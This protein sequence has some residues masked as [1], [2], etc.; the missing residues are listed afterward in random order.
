MKRAPTS[1][2]W[3]DPDRT[4][5]LQPSEDRGRFREGTPLLL[6]VDCKLLLPTTSPVHGRTDYARATGHGGNW[7]KRRTT[8]TRSLS[9][10]VMSVRSALRR[11]FP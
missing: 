6:T 4:I 9:S 11:R 8:E 2:F 10:S 7:K 3:S 1:D 5:G